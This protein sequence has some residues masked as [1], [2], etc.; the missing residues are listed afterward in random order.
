[1]YNFYN[2]ND[3]EFENLCKDIMERLLSINLRRF[4]KGR[5]GGIDLTDNVKNHNVIVQVKHYIR[6]NF[7]NLKTALENE[8]TKV[9]ELNP[10][11]YYV[12][13]GNELTP[14]NITEIFN[15][16]SD[17]MDSDK[18]II[19]LIEINDF[20]EK[21]ENSD[22]VRKHHKLWLY[23]SD[24]LNQINNQNIFIDC[25]SL[26]SDIEEESK[27]FVQT[28][29]FNQCLKCLD[30]HRM[31]LI[32]GQPGVGK[33][34]T[35]KMLLLYYGTQGYSVRYTTNGDISDLKKSLS[36][37]KEIKEA[38]L[39]DDCLGQHYFNMKETQENELTS[40][41]K[42][43]KVHDNKILILNSRLTILN[44]A[45]ERYESFKLFLANK[46]IDELIIN[47]D[48]I[49]PLEK[50]KIFYNHLVSK[51]VP[52]EYY[53]N[54]KKD[55][56]YLKIVMHN[57]F[58]PRIIEYVTLPSNY[59]SIP[60]IEYAVYILKNLDNPNDI[61]KNEYYQRIKEEDRAFL[62]TLYSLTDTIVEYDIL[63]KCFNKRLSLMPNVDCTI[64]NFESVLARLNQ[65]IVKIV[66]YKGKMHI[67]VINPSVND[68]MKQVFMGNELEMQQ[69][70][71]SIIY[72]KQ[73][74]RCY[75]KTEL[76]QAIDKMFTDGSILN[77]DFDSYTIKAYFITS[78]ICMEKYI[79]VNILDTK[80]KEI[81]LYYLSNIYG[82]SIDTRD[83]L[84]PLLSHEMIINKL[85]EK[86]YH[87]FYNIK[88]VFT[89]QFIK[90]LFNKLEL[91][92][93]ILTIN[94]LDKYIQNVKN[95][96]YYN[97]CKSS[98]E[99]SIEDYIIDVSIWEYC[100]KHDI[101]KLL[102]NDTISIYETVNNWIEEDVSSEIYYKLEKLENKKLSNIEITN[103][104]I[105]EGEVDNI[106]NSYLHPDSDRENYNNVQTGN[107]YNFE[108]E[109]N[110]IFER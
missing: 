100:E 60:T 99:K 110:N 56:N 62:T 2:L 98:L 74:N 15:M 51:N 67:G 92:E 87:S 106:I 22:I 104:N 64:N 61:W 29:I 83:I 21:P 107:D 38:I 103:V 34:I 37:S 4:S 11:R 49:N 88:D 27:Y 101:E 1:M 89:D 75:P 33:T 13:C 44:E 109:I 79:S 32:T 50:A 18:N 85:L 105:N 12:C 86:P 69:V 8:K 46:K 94:I 91:D 14:G 78:Y 3:V 68:F 96:E 10:K 19:T 30:K 53:E 45:K 71:K 82:C 9:E 52:K 39:L 58:T 48:T 7:S 6:S 40:L 65:S 73:I 97:L 95:D 77:I 24:I 20:L 5:D 23:S 54:I 41:V 76:L 80:Y 17:Y 93:L 90:N 63:K 81:I 108:S 55:K 35:S 16:F 84:L 36:A 26:L 66:D 28:D 59:L 70:R 31:I 25:E 72:Y 43:V 47:M 42:F 57:N 102:Y